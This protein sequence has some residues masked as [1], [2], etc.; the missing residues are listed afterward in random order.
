MICTRTLVRDD[1]AAR[2]VITK[3]GGIMKKVII[4]GILVLL[5]ALLCMG[6]IFRSSNINCTQPIDNQFGD[7][8]F[9]T[10]IALIEL[11]KVRYGEY[12]EKLRDLKFAG[13]WD[14][15]VLHC[16]EYEKVGAG[17]KLEVTEGWAGKPKLKYPE[18]F[19]QGL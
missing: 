5:I 15:G 2:I 18:D 1:R 10:A 6:C 7:Q 3:T 14:K 4:S 8:Y 12:P 13:D 17:Y 9:K 11:H 16:V 19:W